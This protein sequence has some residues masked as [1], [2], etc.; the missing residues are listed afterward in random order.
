MIAIDVNV[1][2]VDFYYLCGPM[3]G[4]PKYNFPRFGE[5]AK[6]LRRKG[7]V[8]CTP[9]EFDNNLIKHQ[10][11][12]SKHGRERHLASSSP[13]GLSLLRRDLNI[14]MHPNCIGLVCIEGWEDSFGA[15]LETYVGSRFN[16]PLL[17]YTE[18]SLGRVRLRPIA[19]RDSW[20]D[21]Y[22]QKEA[23]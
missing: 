13:M 9:H 7:L 10:V 6:K 4:Y 17:R 3:T 5:V 14:V 22:N 8:V 18:D 16:K 23:A 1:P 11:A 21:D 12:K 20:L 2:D 19:D 15:D